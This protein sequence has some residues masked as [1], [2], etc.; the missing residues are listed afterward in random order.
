[1]LVTDQCPCIQSVNKLATDYDQ[2]G[3][4]YVALLANHTGNDTLWVFQSTDGGHT[5]IK[6]WETWIYG[7]D[8]DIISYDMRIQKETANPFIYLAVVYVHANDT[9]CTF[10]RVNLDQSVSEW[11]YFT[12][13]ADIKHVELDITDEA[14][15]HIYLVYSYPS[16]SFYYLSRQSSADGGA[17]WT[18]GTVTS[19]Q[20]EATGFDL[21]AGPDDQAYLF[22]HDGTDDDLSVARYI[23]YFTSVGG[24]QYLNNVSDLYYDVYIASARHNSYPTNYVVAVYQDGL[25]NSTSTRSW[26]IVSSDGGQ[27]FSAPSHFLVG[28][29]HAIHPFVACTRCGT[30]DQFVG[31]VTQRW[32]GEDSVMAGYKSSQSA[33]WSNLGYKND[34]RATGET[35]PQGNYILTGLGGGMYLIY[36]E[37]GS[38][39]IWYDRAS[40]TSAVEEITSPVV[41]VHTGF[42]QMMFT[43]NF[44]SETTGKLMIFDL[45]GR[46][47]NTIYQGKFN[48]GEN[49]FRWDYLNDDI[50]SGTYIML[51]TTPEHSYSHKFSILN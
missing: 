13:H 9:T 10:R 19:G 12:D 28:D 25:N 47:V 8:L 37:F 6:D 39:N 51:L 43:L 14:N 16:S 31:Y 30:S 33:G 3:F 42:N 2:D 24:F 18:S 27:N 32:S 48:E 17:N 49:S 4:V 41:N 22:W 50:S 38:N 7:S 35:S 26:E 20:K 45:T 44:P 29:N 40:Y 1:M 21:C 15:P 36:R 34:H 5:W 11:H 23:N 46:N